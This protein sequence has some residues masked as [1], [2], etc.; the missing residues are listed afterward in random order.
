MCVPV[1][2]LG[3]LLATAILG[4]AAAG[5]L[6]AQREVPDTVARR[7]DA[8]FGAFDRPTS[9]G[10]AL[11][12]YQNGRIV[13]ARGYGDANLE[14]GVPI[15]PATVF[16]IGSTS[17]QFT[18]MSIL[19]LARDG[20]LA[21]DDDVR[22]FIPELPDYGRRITLRHLLHHTSGI[23]DY[24]TLLSLAG[25]RIEN[26]STDADGLDVIARQRAL[27][28]APGTQWQYSNS[29]FFLLSIVVKRASGQSLRRFAQ[30]HIFEPLGMA[31]THFHD[32]HAMVVPNRATGYV[33]ADSAGPFRIEMSNWE[34]LGDGSVLTTVE[35]LVRWDENFY[36][37]AVGGP[38]VLAE[39][40][41]PGTLDGGKALDYASGLVIGKYRGLK[42][43]EHG[44]AWAGYRAQLLR[45]PTE[46]ASMA[47]LCNLGSAD[48]DGLARKVA[49]V[50]LADRLGPAEHRTASGADTTTSA[51]T[52]A[53]AGSP[54]LPP[55]RLRAAVGTYRDPKLGGVARIALDEGKLALKFAGGSFELHPL[56][57]TE[58][59]LA[60]LDARLQL[61]PAGPGGPRRIRLVGAG[62]DEP[63]FEAIAPARPTAA[64]L[65]GFVGEYFGAELQSTYR[66]AVERGALV[67]HAR[68]L[69]ATPLAPTI[70]DEFEHPTYALTLHFT[71]RAGRVNGFTLASG[72]TQGLRFERRGAA[73]RR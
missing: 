39:M 56:S 21:L 63:T 66:I 46:H 32:D 55:E 28:F 57:A 24:T 70:R 8:V 40:V 38:G 48:P 19:L 65:G 73:Q 3:G 15:G 44:G 68:N 17:K 41:K 9:P 14:L 50:Y 49:D 58:F 12:V 16:D 51:D 60:D 54:A 33:P 30:A 45:F 2:W 35:D 4:S 23:R 6:A 42:T 25:E 62:L 27:N 71:R 67:L 22:K 29:G 7:I 59:T 43:V 47:C 72:R 10:C 69:P 11:G 1:R 53:D 64:A 37:A 20:K 36:S 26:V 31:H 18:A 34:Q 61:V 5:P 52:A 13:H